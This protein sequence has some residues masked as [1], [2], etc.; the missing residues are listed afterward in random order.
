MKARFLAQKVT[1][2]TQKISN[3]NLYVHSKQHHMDN[4]NMISPQTPTT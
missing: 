2:V 1:G 4:L 3:Q